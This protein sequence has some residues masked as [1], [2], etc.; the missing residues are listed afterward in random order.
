MKRRTYAL[1]LPLALVGVGFLMAASASAQVEGPCTITMAGIDAN[2]AATPQTA[3]TVD[4]DESIG[5]SVRS[6]AAITSH[7]V[8]LEFGGF[9]WTVSQ[10]TD[11]GNGWNGRVRVSKY[12]RYG[13]GIY[14][15][16][17]ES[18]GPGACVGSAFVKVTGGS[19]LA[20]AA[21]AGAAAATALGVA[22]LAV[23]AGAAASDTRKA[24]DPLRAAQ[25]DA[26]HFDTPPANWLDAFFWRLGRWCSAAMFPAILLTMAYMVAGA[27]APGA[28]GGL[29]RARWRPRVSALGL[30]GGFLSGLG[31]LVLLQQY[32]LVYP[33]RTVA[34]TGLVL[35][36]ATGI[37]VPSLIR[38]RGVRRVN[39]AV[40]RL[41]EQVAARSAMG[42]APTAVAWTPMHTVPPEG[43]PAWAAPDPS[44]AVVA[45]LDPGL[46][47]RLD[48][49]QGDW[50]RVTASNGWVG[51]V[52]A[53]RLVPPG[54]S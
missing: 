35:G 18:S 34:V 48:E 1:P 30:L 7:R 23:A 5:I 45:T 46:P 25:V 47:L 52:D 50:A 27:G 42:P 19:P 8:M 21:G 36:L 49:L 31:I 9:R 37:A 22:G 29:P 32:A 44:Q 17:G 38:L 6:S 40:A 20:T 26:R 28:P 13:L 41:E 11:T 24:L 15:I 43:M 2:A 33:T 51:W 4:R 14:R 3:I 12:A 53:R 10:G 54:S 16:V 39:A